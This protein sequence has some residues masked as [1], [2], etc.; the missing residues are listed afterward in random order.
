VFALSLIRFRRDL[1]PTRVAGTAL[2]Q[3]A[4]PAATV[5]Q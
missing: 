2:P 3:P 5:T 4:E 1:A